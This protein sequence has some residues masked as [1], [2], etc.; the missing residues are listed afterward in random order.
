MSTPVSRRS[1]CPPLAVL[2][3]ALLIMPAHS[4][5]AGSF[6]L[7]GSWTESDDLGDALGGGISF[8]IPLGPAPVDLDLRATYLEELTSNDFDTLVDDL[9]DGED[10]TVDNGIEMIPVEIGLRFNLF[11]REV[12]NLYL[13]GGGGYYILDTNR[14][15]IDDEFGWYAVLGFVAGDPDGVAFFVEGLWREVEGTVENDPNALD[16]IDDID[17]RDGVSI[18]VGGPVVNMGIT[19]RF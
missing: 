1:S 16:D 11:E 18:D 12:T 14:G 17:F 4:A 3:F 5:F 13:G 10:I 15:S 8:A 9:F 2:L 19:W 7:F 6:S